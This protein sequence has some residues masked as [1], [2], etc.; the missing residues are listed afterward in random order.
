MLFT[1]LTS[2]RS[3]LEHLSWYAY[4]GETRQ[5]LKELNKDKKVKRR[6]PEDFEDANTRRHR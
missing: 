2:S 3:G 4:K 5:Y 1:S 6:A